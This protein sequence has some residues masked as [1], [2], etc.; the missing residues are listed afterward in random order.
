MEEYFEVGQIVNTNGLKGFLKIKPFTDDIKEF[1][2]FKSIYIQTKSELIEFK[3]EK[4]AYVKNMVLLKLQGIDDI[5]EAEKYR[6][7]YIKVERKVLPDLLENSYYIVDLIDCSVVT[8]EGEIL[9]KVDDVF[10]TG[11]NDVYVVKDELGKQILLPAIKEVIKKIDIPNKKI[12]V[13]LMEGL[14]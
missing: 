2:T 14:R 11:S 9:G 8:D 13:K 3:I 5:N 12:T 10:S 1:E 6:N 4:V 7:F